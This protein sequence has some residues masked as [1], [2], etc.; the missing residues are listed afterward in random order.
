LKLQCRTLSYPTLSCLASSSSLQ[1][2]P[3]STSLSLGRSLCLP[4][5]R[6]FNL[7]HWVLA[8]PCLVGIS[9]S[10]VARLCLFRRLSPGPVAASL[11]PAALLHPGFLFDR[12]ANAIVISDT[13]NSAFLLSTLP[14]L[15]LQLQRQ[16]QLAQTPKRTLSSLL[17]F[18]PSRKV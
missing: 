4:S 9:A 11:I 5:N 12:P 8:L 14:R 18:S 15:A 17:I 10:L 6:P 3:S 7:L 13:Q 2:L 16:L 1:Y